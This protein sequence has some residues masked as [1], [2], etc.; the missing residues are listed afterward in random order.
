VKSLDVYR[1]WRISLFTVW[2]TLSVA[3]CVALVMLLLRIVNSG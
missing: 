3:T 2:V 1:R